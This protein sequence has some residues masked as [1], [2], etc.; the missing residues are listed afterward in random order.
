MTTRG[1]ALAPSE[2]D[3]APRKATP[4]RWS[5]RLA[6][7]RARPPFNWPKRRKLR[8][9]LALVLL[10]LAYPVLGT[11]ALWT[12]F[13][14]W[15]LKS[16]D[17]RVE[18]QNPAYTIWPGR[19]RM[20]HVRILEN[21]TTQLILDG[22]DLVLNA[23]MLELVK[24]RVHVT[25]LSAHDVTYQ[26]RVQVKDSK[27]IEERVR[28]YPSLTGLPGINAIRR[29]TT[30]KQEKNEPDWT[31]Q[32]EGLD[33][34]VKELWFFEY[35]YLGKGH[36]RGGFMVGP[37]VMQV[38]TAVQDL[39]PGEVHFGANELVA[40][41]IQGQV[42]ANIP[43]LDPSEHA[44]ASFMEL[45]TARVNLHAAVQS[46]RNLS[47][48]APGIEFSHGAGPLALDAYL[49]GG[50]LGAKSHLDFETSSFRV[51]GDG[52]GVGTDFVLKFDAAG[53]P[54]GLPVVRSSS[55]STY[56]SLARG[57]RQ[58][59]VQVHGHAEEAHLDTIQL[60]RATDLKSAS[61]RMPDIRSVDL[62]DLGGVLPQKTP[63]EVR[64]G[65]LNGSLQLDMDH[66][67]WVRGPLE[68]DVSGLDLTAS[69]VDV[70]G[71]VG[72]KTQLRVNP[73]RGVYE[74]NLALALR[75]V[76][77]HAGD[78]STK[79]WWANVV[80]R[81]L[82][83][84]VREPPSFD[85][86][87]SIQTQSLAPLLEALADK[88]VVSKLVPMFTKLAN[89]RAGATVAS[90]GPVTDVLLASESDVWDVAGRVRKDAEESRFAV[91]VGGQA[92]SL[93]V[94]DLGH[95]LELMPFA[96]TGWLNEKLAG[97]PKPV[98]MQ[99]DKP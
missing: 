69:G 56:V 39:G 8:W 88:E 57:A 65:T 25:E 86:K 62:R 74:T 29:A 81:D 13:V 80:G 94:A 91:V 55:K 54:E 43:K 26:M 30:E 2:L 1:T 58:F 36:L 67:Y 16:E 7:L 47:A 84:R 99:P 6:A 33:V 79:G 92:V 93:G 21:G 4:S 51:K 18:I 24:R 78:Y 76:N 44:D 19:V 48:Y 41:D 11:V 37:H 70:S 17:L 32:V 9:A 22:H 3:R 23:R 89:F 72:I 64:E 12:G 5:S 82:T 73:K 20:K 28:A 77:T 49:D 90:A 50:K 83:Y 40:N 34:G 61:V 15:I 85:G 31:V 14:E 45:V 35:R 75:D 42:T 60:S 38:S 59:T 63:M 66:E 71:H 96:K 46:L 68:V 27:G 95:G 52:F 10:L 98:R 87:V 53:S 97:F